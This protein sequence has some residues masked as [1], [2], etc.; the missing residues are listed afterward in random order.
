M[1][2]GSI[3]WY[4]PLIGGGLFGKEEN[5]ERGVFMVGVWSPEPSSLESAESWI[6]NCSAA[7]VSMARFGSTCL[8]C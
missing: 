2:H 6:A 7:S 1:R 4:V 8:R 5:A 3:R